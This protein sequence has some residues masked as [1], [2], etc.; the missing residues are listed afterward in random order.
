MR[1]KVNRF[2]IKSDSDHLDQLLQSYLYK[3]TSLRVVTLKLP[4]AS[5]SC[6]GLVIHRILGRMPPPSFLIQE[7]GDICNFIKFTGNSIAASPGPYLENHNYR[8]S[9]R[10]NNWIT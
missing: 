6:G 2:G 4:C 9:Q 3:S 5:E 8:I 1:T 10:E 7:F